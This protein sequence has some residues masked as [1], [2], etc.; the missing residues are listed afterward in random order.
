MHLPRL[1]ESIRELKAP[2]FILD[3]GSNDGTI[4]IGDKFGAVI[5]THAFENHPKQWD[6]ALKNFNIQTPWVICLDADHTVTPELKKHLLDFSNDKYQNVNG[7]YFNRKNFFKGK[8]IMHGGYY[9]FYQLKMIRYGIGYSDLSE[10]MDHRMV[11]PGNTIIWKDGYILEENLKENNIAFWIDKHNRYSD[12]VAHEEVERL[13]QLR[14]QTV[15]PHFWGS[16]DG[17]RAWLKQLWWRMPRYVRPSVYLIYRMFFQLGILDGQTGVTFHFLQAFWFRLIVD[18]KIDEI[19]KQQKPTVIV[20]NQKH[21]SPIRFVVSFIVLFVV[22]YYFN[23]FYFGITAPGGH[24]SAFLNDHLNYIRWLREG[25]LNVSAQIINWLGFSAITDEYD[26]LVAG[27]GAIR[28][29]Y[30]CLGLGVISFFAAFVLSY[31]KRWKSKAIFLIT[32]ILGIEIL[33]IARLV[34]LALFWQ[35]R[36]IIVFD[37]HAIFNVILYIIIAISL[38]FWVKHDDNQIANAAN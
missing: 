24:Y 8:W 30:S 2:I 4:A 23:I 20:N 5:L 27:H 12:L 31:P 15:K 14:T 10:N 28:L 22:F 36:G 29:V 18:I 7:I 35:H 37:Q 9:P 21:D 13:N 3:S 25:L 26:L 34:L 16:P 19:I 6:F 17:R 33:N 32:G 1:L 11:V 38:Y